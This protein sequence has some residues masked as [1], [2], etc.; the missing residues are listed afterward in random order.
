MGRE[1]KI[2]FSTMQ[3]TVITLFVKF[4]GLIKQSVLAACCGATMKTDA[5]F[6]ATGT[7]VNLSTVIFSA[8]SISLLTIHTNILFQQGREQS[9]K[10]ISAVLKFFVPMAFGLTAVFYLGS[11][12][13]AKIIAPAYRGEELAI[14]L[15][16][17]L[18]CQFHLFCGAI[19]LQLM[20]FW[21]RINNLFKEKAKV[22]FK[23][24]F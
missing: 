2:L 22:C 11:S 9:N 23:I 12:G 20:S 5:F 17:S 7:M 19:F 18:R 16:I 4:L 21:K 6:L 15:I 8:I 10:L 3:V 1:K 13:I 14:Y 24:Y